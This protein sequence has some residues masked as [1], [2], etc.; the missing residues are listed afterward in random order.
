[1]A[2]TPQQK[3]GARLLAQVLGAAAVTGGD[4]AKDPAWRDT[5]GPA[6][7]GDYLSVPLTADGTCWAQLHLHRDGAARLT[8]I[9]RFTGLQ[10]SK[11]LSA[12]I[13][14]SSGSLPQGYAVTVTT[15]K[16]MTCGHCL[17]AVEQEIG[18][19][20]GVTGTG[21]ELDT[22][23]GRCHGRDPARYRG[24][25]IPTRQGVTVEDGTHSSFR[26]R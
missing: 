25:G 11:A 21:V 17:S 14:A 16:G 8:P 5:L 1:M 23:A 26:P 13:S 6:G 7:V 19:C 18:N 9:T 15:V 3:A 4:L 2:Q 22:G 24:A 12:L 10:R 20:P